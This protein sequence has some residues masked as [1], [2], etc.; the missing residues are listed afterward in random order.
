MGVV[1]YTKRY[2]LRRFIN[3]VSDM[4]QRK[5]SDEFY[6]IDLCDKVLGIKASRQHTFDF[7]RG[8]GNP[9]RKLPV[10]A[11]YLEL[12]LVIEYRERQHT[13]SV[14]FFNKKT[15]V[16]GVSRDEQRR[17]YDQRRRDV[18]PKH[19][20]RLV[21]ISYS[22]LKHD[23]RKRLVR[24]RQN[25]L[26]VIKRL[27]Q[28]DKGQLH[29]SNES[30]KKRNEQLWLYRTYQKKYGCL[31]VFAIMAVTLLLVSYL[32]ICVFRFNDLV[33]CAVIIA[34]LFI[35]GSICHHYTTVIDRRKQSNA[36]KLRNVSSEIPP[37]CC[38]VCGSYKIGPIEN[39]EYGC[40]D[41]GLKWRQSY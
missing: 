30:E 21:E 31:L 23:S 7:L 19:G 4:A 5:N 26:A 14:A 15:T 36:E 22:D 3:F 27:L 17:I 33:S 41:C 40:I 1:L 34:L 20:I 35:V 24:D 13:E 32:S 10:D 8:D 39:G 37:V 12:N 16:S 2:S 18:L 28:A 9:S 11:Y 25:D 6:V 38:P 29:V